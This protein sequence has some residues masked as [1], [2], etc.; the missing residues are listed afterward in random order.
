M[1]DEL[2]NCSVTEC[3]AATYIIFFLINEILSDTRTHDFL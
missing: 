2:F 3:R 1:G